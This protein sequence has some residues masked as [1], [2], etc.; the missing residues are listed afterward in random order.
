MINVN[1][2]DAR[3]FCKWLTASERKA[4]RLDENQTYR[5][6]TDAEWSALAGIPHEG[7]NTPEQRDG[8]FRQ[9]LWGTT[10]PPPAGSGNFADMKKGGIPG[11]SDGWVQTSPVGSFPAMANGLFDMTGNV[12]QWVEDSYRGPQ[13]RKTWGV[14]RGG[15]WGTSQQNE[16]QLGYR[17]VVD[18]KERDP[19]FGFR[20]VIELGN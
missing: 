18:P 19:L 10:W 11:Y 2:D 14:L 13:A 1:S 3:E 17:D 8:K 12:W 20:C 6:P 5:L 15:S 16:L 4:G 7:G 9:Y